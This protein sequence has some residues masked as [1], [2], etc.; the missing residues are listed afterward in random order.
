[1][2]L[3]LASVIPM[4]SKTLTGVPELRF[5]KSVGQITERWARWYDARM[6]LAKSPQDQYVEAVVQRK[7]AATIV[8][9]SLNAL[10]TSIQTW[11][12][13]YLI[14]IKPSGS[15]AKG[16]AV[17]GSADIDL[18]ISLRNDVLTGNTPNLSTLYH[19]L[20]VWLTKA[21]YST[22][23]QNVSIGV[24][25]PGIKVDLVPAVKYPGNTNDHSVFKRKADTWRKTNIDTHINV[26]SNSGRTL[27]IRA[28]KIW[29]NLHGL[30]ISSFYLEL[31]VLQALSG[32]ALY[33][34]AANLFHVMDFMGS[35]LVTRAILDPANTA[36]YVSDELT[37]SE[38]QAIAR[39]AIK[40]RAEPYWEQVIW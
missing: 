6:S 15:Y 22:R 3:H 38:K 18:L 19:S 1:V 37:Q 34:P 40:S 39:Q 16:T 10:I 20:N 25:L 30:D 14:E 31:V 12:T 13:Q 7:P 11:A 9:G 23:L 2:A 8:T 36:N 28:V 21:E 35:Q 24:W 26:V 4:R 5:E 17:A 32:K 29:R 33:N 27:D